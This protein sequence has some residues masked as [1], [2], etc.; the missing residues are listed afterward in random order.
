[1]ALILDGT[2]GITY[3]SW[4][5]S[6]RPASPAAGETGFNTTVNLLE[7]YSGNSAIGWVSA[8]TVA[9]GAIA[10]NVQTVTANYTMTAN[11]SGVSSGPISL[12]NAVT[13][14][15]PSGSRW[16]IV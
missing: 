11:S 15:L 10:Q 5:N 13:V 4:T 16:V 7:T 3:P 2:N 6:T 8:S 12:A 14:T 1:M 9:N